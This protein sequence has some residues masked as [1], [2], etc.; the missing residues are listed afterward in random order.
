[1]KVV[2]KRAQKSWSKNFKCEHCEQI[3]NVDLSDL[4]WRNIGEDSDTGAAMSRVA[5]KCVCKRIN[6]VDDKVP[7]WVRHEVFRKKKGQK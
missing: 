6:I 4:H 1:M 7:E 5:F 2:K 3:I